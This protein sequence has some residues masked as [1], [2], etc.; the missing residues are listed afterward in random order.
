MECS[1][2]MDGDTEPRR[3]MAQYQSKQR[4]LRL[5]RF[6]RASARRLVEGSQLHREEAVVV[7]ATLDYQVITKAL[8][9]AEAL[10]NS[11]EFKDNDEKGL[12]R[13]IELC[14][15]VITSDTDIN[16]GALGKNNSS[17]CG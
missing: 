1:K 5:G 15:I 7:E 3:L 16:H 6:A 13:L 10:T 8:E 4:R 9:L 17:C 2:A 14:N 11:R 12:E